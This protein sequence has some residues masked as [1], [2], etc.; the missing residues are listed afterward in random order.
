MK[1]YLPIIKIT[2]IYVII[3]GTWILF[4]DQILSW[5]ITNQETYIRAQTVKG[6]FFVLV[7]AIILY[8]TILHE[9]RR[10]W[11]YERE[12]EIIA[13]FSKNIRGILDPQL[14][15]Y[16][17]INHIRDL[18]QAEIVFFGESEPQNKS[19]KFS[20]LDTEGDPVTQYVPVN[21]PLI[22]Q[23]FE[24]VKTVSSLEE[25]HPLEIPGFMIDSNLQYA[26]TPLVAREKV[27]GMI[28]FAKKGELISSDV[29]LLQAVAEISS[30]AFYAADLLQDNATQI[31]R[32]STFR[33][34]DDSILTHFSTQ[35]LIEIL[36]KEFTN[37]LDTDA[38]S[39]TVY[40]NE[41]QRLEFYSESGLENNDERYLEE[42]CAYAKD[43]DS[44]LVI[45]NTKSGIDSQRAFPVHHPIHDH[46]LIGYAMAPL[47]NMGQLMGIV[48]VFS[49]K[50]INWDREKIQF[51]EA[52]V[53]QT[54]IAIDKVNMVVNLKK[55]N[56]E[57][58]KSYEE[59]LEGW[60]RAMDVRDHE[61]ENHTQ[62]VTSLTI[63]MGERLGLSDEQLI[64][65]RRGALLHD[66]GKLGVPDNILLKKGKLTDEE[67]EIMRQ[68]PATAAELIK[69][70]AFLAP[71]ITIPYFHH[72]KWDGSGYPQGLSAGEIPIEARIFSIVDVWD[73]LSSD[74]PYR[75]ALSHFEV[76]N[77]IFSQSGS[78]FDPQLVS[79]FL[80]LLLKEGLLS[81]EDLLHLRAN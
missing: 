73:A 77:Y 17:I 51:F 70:I 47:R 57:L 72:E 9:F 75:K 49:R 4:S 48:E 29:H 12:L 22:K 37:N 45:Q 14:L 20:S 69:P 18:F 30:Q 31:Q 23:I 2:S 16:K 40:D 50:E 24:D 21:S 25:N 32:L 80:D 58:I 55:S 27:I 62:R 68:H 78:H 39:V 63:K 10:H 64:Q 59:T 67:W 42:A 71:A 54:A 76:A 52:L 60:S 5:L 6:W 7:T 3:A 19:I 81:H 79:T 38:A 28:G 11:E 56:I 35:D 36:L 34:I 8:R 26:I 44:I 53:K 13:V 15:S 41:T 65:M 66:I 33:K 74:R 61:T 46:A 43:H 1:Q